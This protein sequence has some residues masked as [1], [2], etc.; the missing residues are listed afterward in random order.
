MKDAK[1]RR[2]VESS[3]EAALPKKMQLTVLED[4]V[5]IL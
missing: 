1:R 5:F 4:K 3:G 2:F